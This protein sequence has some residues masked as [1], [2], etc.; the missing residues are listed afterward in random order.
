MKSINKTKIGIGLLIIIVVMQFFRVDQSNGEANTSKDFIHMT[1]P[2]GEV[3]MILTSACYDCHSVRTEY[4]W[5]ANIAPVSWWIKHHV[6]EGSEHLNFSVWGD[7][8]AKRQD[9]KLEEIIEEVEE[10][11]MP[12]KSYT[13]MHAEAK[14]SDEQKSA[15]IDWVKELRKSYK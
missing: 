1:Q 6:D 8:S 13:W 15:L 12:L 9:H 4:P 10:G 5:Y 7:Y 2:A 3:K 11:E 14:L